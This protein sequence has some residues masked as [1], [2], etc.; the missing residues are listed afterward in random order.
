MCTVVMCIQQGHNEHERSLLFAAFGL[1]AADPENDSPTY[2]VQ[3]GL[4]RRPAAR[5]L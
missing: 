4:G 5:S 1:S 3:S 2:L